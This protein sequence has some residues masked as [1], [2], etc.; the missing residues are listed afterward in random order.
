MPQ[1][2]PFILD[3]LLAL[4]AAVRA[5]E[6]IPDSPLHHG[7]D[8]LCSRYAAELDHDFA[9]QRSPEPAVALDLFAGLWAALRASRVYDGA[10]PAGTLDTQHWG[11]AA[12]VAALPWRLT[13]S[14][15]R[16]RAEEVWQ[17]WQ[18]QSR[19]QQW[20]DDQML[21]LLALRVDPATAPAQTRAFPSAVEAF[22]AFLTRDEPGHKL[23]AARHRPGAVRDELSLSE[24]AAA[25]AADTAALT[26][27]DPDE[28]ERR[29]T[30]VRDAQ[31]L[32]LSRRVAVTNTYFPDAAEWLH[33]RWAGAVTEWVA[34][35]QVPIPDAVITEMRHRHPG[36]EEFRFDVHRAA[37]QQTERLVAALAVSTDGDLARTDTGDLALAFQAL[38][39]ITERARDD[40]PD[41]AD[42]GDKLLDELTARSPGAQY[43]R[44]VLEPERGDIGRSDPHRE[45]LDQSALQIARAYAAAV[46]GSPPLYE[47]PAPDSLLR[48]LHELRQPITVA[49]NLDE[50]RARTDPWARA[51]HSWSTQHPF[52]GRHMALLHRQIEVAR[53][54]AARPDAPAAAEADVTYRVGRLETAFATHAVLG[55]LSLAPGPLPDATRRA[56]LGWPPADPLRSLSASIAQQ[57]RTRQD[58]EMVLAV[59]PTPEHA[60]TYLAGRLVAMEDQTRSFEDGM[61]IVVRTD[62]HLPTADLDLEQEA[63]PDS[64][65]GG[66]QALQAGNVTLTRKALE[67]SRSERDALQRALTRL[68]EIEPASAALT[69]L[70]AGAIAAATARAMARRAEP[71]ATARTV[72]VTDPGHPAQQAAALHQQPTGPPLTP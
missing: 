59:F 36:A 2:A 47:G 34:R 60:R 72:G 40:A 38:Q 71:P 9:R 45:R 26:A 16:Q 51:A 17:T 70:D 19:L 41:F 53:E 6:A 66:W 56:E 3:H 15:L 24:L 4:E 21:Y 10:R 67:D 23:A 1:P 12:L 52:A 69:G 32:W 33:I 63:M 62:P 13:I 43:L 35:F 11:R 28:A 54:A 65:P 27:T 49:L 42:A 44:G 18:Q 58:R 8:V 48:T 39:A 29:T 14:D 31:A 57:Q 55:R 30:A 22:I 37:V 68:E 20:P 64:S 61:A 25:A 50:P 5:A 46:H 7:S